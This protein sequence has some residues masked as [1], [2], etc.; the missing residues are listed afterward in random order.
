MPIFAKLLYEI[1]YSFHMPMFIFCN[2]LTSR[3]IYIGFC[4]K[5]SRKK[6]YY[7]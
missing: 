5:D 3:V 2:K 4:V 6:L 7:V 1:A